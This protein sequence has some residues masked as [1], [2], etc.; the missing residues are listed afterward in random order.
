[1][2][3][4][5]LLKV[6]LIS[7]SAT[8]CLLS[9]LGNIM[10]YELH[11]SQVSS[12]LAMTGVPD[13]I[14]VMRIEAQWFSHVVLLTILAVKLA[15]CLFLFKGAYSMLRAINHSNE[16][17]F[18]SKSAAI[19]GIGLIVLL[20]FTVFILAA[21]TLFL[22]WMQGEQAILALRFAFIYMASFLLIGCFVA[23]PEPIGEKE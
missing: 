23:Q 20:L 21:D 16:A 11:L 17:F 2:Y 12:T 1:M 13:E 8:W 9:G 18:V 22:I 14:A 6:S 10:G 15:A 19:Q 7:V 4:I 5:R 3:L